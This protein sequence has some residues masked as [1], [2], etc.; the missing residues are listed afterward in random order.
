M[1]WRDIP[2]GMA[3]GIAQRAFDAPARSI[4][5]YREEPCPAA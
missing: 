1:S 5:G 2:R 4:V 3:F